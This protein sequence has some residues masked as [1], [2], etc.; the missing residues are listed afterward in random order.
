MTNIGINQSQPSSGGIDHSSIIESTNVRSLAALFDNTQQQVESSHSQAHIEDHQVAPPKF[1]TEL[2]EIGAS[3]VEFIE[4]RLALG[5]NFRVQVV[6]CGQLVFD[7]AAGKVLEDE[8]VKGLK[9]ARKSPDKFE[10]RVGKY[11]KSVVGLGKDDAKKE[12]KQASLDKTHNLYSKKETEM[13]ERGITRRFHGNDEGGFNTVIGRGQIKPSHIPAEILSDL[14]VDNKVP[15]KI[16]NEH[17]LL[18]L[19]DHEIDSYPNHM[20]SSLPQP[21]LKGKS[22]KEAVKDLTHKLVDLYREAYP[23]KSLEDTYILARDAARVITYQTHYDLGH[24]SG[25]SHSIKHIMHNIE[26]AESMMQG[27]ESYNAEHI[28]DTDRFLVYL[29][30]MYHDI[31]YTVPMAQHT[32]N[33][34]SASSD[35]PLTGG[36]FLEANEEYFTD[37]IG[38]AGYITLRDS[39]FLHSHFNSDF[40][41]SEFDKQVGSHR[42]QEPKIHPGIV[43]SVTSGSDCCAVSSDIKLQEFW[44]NPSVI[45]NT[46]RLQYAFQSMI[47][48]HVAKVVA[49]KLSDLTPEKLNTLPLTEFTNMSDADIEKLSVEEKNQLRTVENYVDQ[50][51]AKAMK[52]AKGHIKFGVLIDPEKIRP[53]GVKL[54]KFGSAEA[55]VEYLKTQDFKDKLEAKIEAAAEELATSP[56]AILSKEE[57]IELLSTFASV[58]VN[59]ISD[60]WAISKKAAKAANLEN[61]SDELAL[62][63][64]RFSS[65]VKAIDRNFN[66][67]SVQKA[68]GQYGAKFQGIKVEESDKVS[69]YTMVSKWVPSKAVEH[70]RN[71]NSAAF[72]AWKKLGDELGIDEDEIELYLNAYMNYREAKD[73]GDDYAPLKQAFTNLQ[74][75]LNH[76][77]SDKGISFKS[78]KGTLIIEGPK[79]KMHIDTKNPGDDNDVVQAFS[80]VLKAV[81]DTEIRDEL[82]A[83][84]AFCDSVKGKDHVSVNYVIDE[85][86]D[87]RLGNLMEFLPG[88]AAEEVDPLLEFAETIHDALSEAFIGD[89]EQIPQK[90]VAV[91]QKIGEHTFDTDKYIKQGLA[92]QIVA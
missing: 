66:I 5:Q 10:G 78:G 3:Q 68:F 75:K 23:N 51:R 35:H 15:T 34:P 69:Y 12:M 67:M 38:E 42:V 27:I 46:G 80:N 57:Y 55:L 8:A 16:N 63:Q 20:L 49:D 64:K 19:L 65:L 76:D 36:K 61:E 58:K 6:K 21:D 87:K 82:L 84:K 2:R 74:M 32:T 37:L 60:A 44:M 47:K 53:E 89:R 17:E 43:R 41:T 29:V 45:V 7:E 73:K 24:W 62:A 54:S 26:L 83:I 18:E 91:A 33:W 40:D 1:N 13:V 30:H 72:A 92:E 11:G 77:N 14:E 25:S 31:G 81:S 90:L 4:P 39:V 52:A 85:L 79:G 71:T 56:K 86:I 88:V 28:S 48:R 9:N 59:L 22:Q 70:L 50:A